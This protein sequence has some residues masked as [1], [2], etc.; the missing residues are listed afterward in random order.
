[1]KEA[2]L[3]QALDDGRVECQLCAHRCVI[4]DGKWGI[5]RVRQN[6][7]GKLYSIVYGQTIARHV[8][9]IEKK[10]LFHFLPGSRAY[11]V[12][13]PGCNFHCQWCQNWDISQMPRQRGLPVSQEVTPA[14]IAEDAQRTGAQSIAYTYTEPTIFFEYVHDISQLAEARGIHNV[15]VTNGFMTEE[16]LEAFRPR[17][18]AAN[19]DLKSF[20]DET[21]RKYV[22]GRLQPVLDSMKRM[23]EMGVWLEVT[24]LVIPGLNDDQGEL[25]EVAEFIAGELGPH[26]P[27]HISRFHP[28]AQMNETPPTPR[29]TLEFAREIGYEAGLHYVYL[30]NVSA[31]EDTHCHQCGQLLIGRSAM[32]ISE[33]HISS[34]GRCPACNAEIP[35]FGM[36]NCPAPSP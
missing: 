24:M 2:M 3:Y 36:G 25:R 20:K 30:G 13:T 4:S 35:G 16:M 8:D 33:D 1:M 22:G 18:D 28:A 17:L 9:P 10:P 23:K 27:W 19:V 7:G 5:C 32:R 6:Q 11:S 14:E 15:I 31:G 26:T 34:Q 12:A 21:Y 29:S